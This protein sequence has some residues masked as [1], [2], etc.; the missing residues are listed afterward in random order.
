[1]SETQGVRG[2]Q[3]AR[4][5]DVAL[6]SLAQEMGERLRAQGIEVGFFIMVGY[7]GEEDRDLLATVEHIRRSEPDVV[8]TTT[9][10]PIR[11]TEYAT[12]VADRSMNPKLWAE[13]SD[14][15]LPTWAR[16]LGVSQPPAPWTLADDAGPYAG[17]PQCPK[18]FKTVRFYTVR[19]ADVI[20][21]SIVKPIEIRRKTRK[22]SK[23][24]ARISAHW[25]DR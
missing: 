9:A 17:R 7:E 25:E 2:D 3:P 16:A 15:A 21:L 20:F 4:G 23:T 10:Y 19:G 18:L 22:W 1:M 5:I 12:A 6:D 8:L 13:S 24:K 14:I 11:G